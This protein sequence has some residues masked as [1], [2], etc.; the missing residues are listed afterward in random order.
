VVRRKWR[1]PSP[2]LVK[3]NVDAAVSRAGEVVIME[4]LVQSAE[5]KLEGFWEH[6]QEQ[7][8]VYLIQLFWRQCRVLNLS[9]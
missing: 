4:L 6:Q 8:K 5:M 7:S 2:G 3:L 1:P 9:V